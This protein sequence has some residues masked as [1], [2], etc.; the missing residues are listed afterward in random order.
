MST[1]LDRQAAHR[2]IGH[3]KISTFMLEGVFVIASLEKKNHREE[4]LMMG[5]FLNLGDEV[6]AVMLG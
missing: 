2:L 1:G 3:P 5:R 4:Q 6:S